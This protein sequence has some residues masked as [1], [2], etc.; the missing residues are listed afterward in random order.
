[1]TFFIYLLIFKVIA[2]QDMPLLILKNQKL[3]KAFINFIIKKNG[4]NS[5]L[6]KFVKLIL[7]GFKVKINYCLIL[8]V[9]NL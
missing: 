4:K 6:K 5:N 9:L 7:L 3:L 8:I 1:M 2:I